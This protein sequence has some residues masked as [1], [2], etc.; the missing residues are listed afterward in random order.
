MRVVTDLLSTQRLPQPDGSDVAPEDVS[1][2]CDVCGPAWFYLGREIT[3]HGRHGEP[4]EIT[5]SFC[6]SLI[7]AGV[8]RPESG[9]DDAGK[10]CTRRQWSAEWKP[11]ELLPSFTS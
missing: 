4:P 9:H 6:Q 11:G 7:D 1:P 8:L 2:W 10:P 3:L 5:C